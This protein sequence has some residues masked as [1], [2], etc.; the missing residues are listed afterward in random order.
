MPRPLAGATVT[1]RNVLVVAILIAATAGCSARTPASGAVTPPATADA[2]PALP[3][4]PRA[5]GP[6]AIRVTYPP[7]NAAIAS[8]DSNFIFGSVGHG[9]ARLTINGTPV[10][11]L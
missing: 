6:L 4:V 8:R 10:P 3:P 11:V 2:P 1:F 5:T 9:D 7:A